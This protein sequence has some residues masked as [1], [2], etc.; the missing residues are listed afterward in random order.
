[1]GGTMENN[2]VEVL[3]APFMKRGYSTLR[4]NFRGVGSNKGTYDNGNGEQE[5]VLGAV[6]FLTEKEK[7]SVVLAG[8]SFGA[9]IA[10]KVI[11]R[12]YIFSDVI[13]VSPPV[14]FLDFDFTGMEG[15]IGLIVCG[16][17][18][19]FCPASRLRSIA[20]MVKCRLEFVTGA[21]HF[22]F[23]QEHLIVDHLYSYLPRWGE[24]NA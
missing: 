20:K 7:T 4:F 8:Y 14:D 6:G 5:D 2:V 13:L 3:I 9:W 21:D 17:R 23:G 22:Y 24:D 10:L 18:D 16:Y 1:M 15:R 19:Q 12:C 11:G